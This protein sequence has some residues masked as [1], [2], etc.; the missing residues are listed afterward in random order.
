MRPVLFT[1]PF[2]SIGVPA[3][4]TALMVGFLL[5]VFFARRRAVMIGL[6]KQQVFDMGF[7]AVLGGVVGARLMHVAVFYPSYFYSDDYWPKW[8]GSFG[9]LGAI[10][11]TWNG[12]LVFY[13][14][15][16]GGVAALW[17]YARRKHIPLVDILDFVAPGGALGLAV[18]RVGCFLNGCCFGKPSDLPWAVRFPAWSDATHRSHIYNHQVAQGFITEGQAI[19]PVH[20]A[21]LYETLA[22][23]LMFT[24]LYLFYPHRKYAG[25][26]SAGFGM[27]YCI[28]RF[29][30][31][32]FR[33]DSG[34]EHIFWSLTIYQLMSVVLFV[35]FAIWMLVAGLRRRPPFVPQVTVSRKSGKNQTGDSSQ[36]SG[37]KDE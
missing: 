24:S 6:D 37:G 31:E 4:G 7:F 2:T 21:Q 30:N 35:V 17:I 18:T 3:Y 5:A 23:L 15:L 1:I 13:G 10:F 25:Q 8:M 33:N 12:G 36:E 16:I 28:W 34:R 32:Y 26:I 29:C 9:W 27:L 19:L 14:G 11:S 20:P 22:G